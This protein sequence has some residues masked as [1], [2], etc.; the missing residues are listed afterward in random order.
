MAP[1][2][3]SASRQPV[4]PQRQTTS[5]SPA[6]WMWP[7]SP[8]APC[9]PRWSR[10]SEMIPAPIPVPTLTTTTLSWPTA[11][12]DRHSPSARTL[13]SLSTQTGAP[14][15]AAKRSRTRVAVPAGHDRRRDRAARRELDGPGHAD[16]DAPQ[17]PRQAARAGAEALEQLVDAVEARRPGRPRCRP[18][19][20]DGRGSGRRASSAATSMLV[21]PRSAT[22]TW[23]A[24]RLERELARRP[25]AG[26]RS[27]V[28]LDDEPP[29]DE[30]GDALGDDA[31]RQRPS[32]RRAPPASATARAGSRR[33]PRRARRASRPDRRARGEST[34]RPRRDR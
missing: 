6:T 5:R 14:Y 18:A 24:P 15:R 17:A 21:A 10:P 3:A 7:T 11:T 1:P 31:A 13:T 27:Q 26:A 33:G 29:V 16:A 8:A 30:L 9:A 2:P 4:L 19:R 22:R 28:A 20:R 34:A 23:P 12:P 32:A 25:A